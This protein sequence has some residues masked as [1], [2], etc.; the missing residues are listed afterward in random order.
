[1]IEPQP[2]KQI[3]WGIGIMT[4]SIVLT[5][6]LVILQTIVIRKTN[7]IAIKADRLH[8]QSDLWTNLSILF[9]LVLTIIGVQHADTVVALLL[10]VY[11]LECAIKLGYE[12]I[13]MLLDHSLPEEVTQ[14]VIK[15]T[16]GYPE[17]IEIHD[18]RTRQSGKTKFIQFHLV[19]SGSMSLEQ[20]HYLSEMV[21]EK[22]V[23]L[24]ED[25]EIFI[26][27]DPHTQ[28]IHPIKQS[29]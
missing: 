3:T 2:L 6:V 13:Q 15:I 28:A 18:I 12:A 8:Y 22:I 14:S 17:I 16:E 4:L 9:A 23:A 1:L 29:A 10:G 11:I 19:F 26:H 21:E 7:S 5:G 27:L 24:Y 20:A 25:A